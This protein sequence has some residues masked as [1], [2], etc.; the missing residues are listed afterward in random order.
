MAIHNDILFVADRLSHKIHKITTGG[1]Y[2]D[3]FGEKGVDPGKLNY[4]CSIAVSPDGM[5][6]FVCDSRWRVQVF[7]PDWSLSHVIDGEESGIELGNPLGLAFDLS[8]NVHVACYSSDSVIVLTPSGEFVHQYGQGQLSG[9]DDIAIDSSGY[10]IVANLYSGKLLIFT[11]TG[12]VCFVHSCS[13][14]EDAGAL[15]GVDVSLT[16]HSI[17]TAY[18]GSVNK[19]IKF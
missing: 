17:W 7:N 9:P 16:D 13:T 4:P 1:K 8:G 5:L 2:L 14:D 15:W 11:P 10:S 6:R 19:L 12:S 3:S 18:C